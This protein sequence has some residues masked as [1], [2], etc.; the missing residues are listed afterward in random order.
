MSTRCENAVS[1]CISS[2]TFRATGAM[3]LGSVLAIVAFLFAPPAQA[4]ASHW[5][6]DPYA[7]G[8]A[9]SSW[10]L[11]S[12]SVPGGTASIK[13]SNA[14]STNWI[15]YSGSKQSTTKTIKDH[16]TNRWTRNEV[17]NL[18]WSYSMQV[19]GPG[20]RP[21]TATIKIGSTTTTATCS[22]TCAWT[23]S[24]PAQPVTERPYLVSGIRVA[25]SGSVANQLLNNYYSK[26]GKQVVI[27]WSFFARNAKL[28]TW[29]YALKVDGYGSYASTS[30]ADGNDMFLAL[31]TF[32][33]WRNSANCFVVT[34]IYDFAPWYPQYWDAKLGAAKVFKVYASGCGF[35]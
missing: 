1:R 32:S 6:T 14:C 12:R 33:V 25:D 5:N 20:T 26:S 13:V 35:R 29:A 22:V 28:K 16:V 2:K 23:S 9:K 21:I 4:A 27:D 10:T 31:G 24:S 34:D 17:D 15:E 3:A 18:P 19:Y 7:T 11:S 8:C 30:E